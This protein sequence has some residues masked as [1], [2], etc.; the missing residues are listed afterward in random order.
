M[1]AWLSEGMGGDL[2][3]CDDMGGGG[4]VV[5]SEGYGARER[6]KKRV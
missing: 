5:N 6:I 1:D 3:T 4:G 2:S